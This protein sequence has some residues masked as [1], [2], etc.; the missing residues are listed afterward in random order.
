M[1]CVL[2]I[3][4]PPEFNLIGNSATHDS[5][6]LLPFLLLNGALLTS[7][8]IFAVACGTTLMVILIGYISSSAAAAVGQ[9]VTTTNTTTDK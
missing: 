1:A 6:P 5:F 9:T 3:S 8:L 7:C 2:L 4:H